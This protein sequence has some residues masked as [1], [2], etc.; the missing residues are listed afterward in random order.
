LPIPFSLI[1]L[2]LR[3]QLHHQRAPTHTSYSVPG[4][5]LQDQGLGSA[6]PIAKRLNSNF[7]TLL[8]ERDCE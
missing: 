5:N 6:P 7:K 1:A 3:P 4:R 2:A 8:D